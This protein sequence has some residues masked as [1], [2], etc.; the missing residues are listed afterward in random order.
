MKS[1]PWCPFVQRR[2]ASPNTLVGTHKHVENSL[3]LSS[4]QEVKIGR[5]KKGF[6]KRRYLSNTLLQITRKKKWIVCGDDLFHVFLYNNRETGPIQ[7]PA[8]RPVS[9][10]LLFTLHSDESFAYCHTVKFELM[11]K[12][13]TLWMKQLQ[14]PSIWSDINKIRITI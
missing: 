7:I 8:N 2:D 3:G 10:A 13:S 4:V 11:K 9:T 14:F 6:P 1:S 5:K 12:H